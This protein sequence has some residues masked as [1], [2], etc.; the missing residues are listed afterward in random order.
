MTIWGK[1]LE[2][3][4]VTPT[5]PSRSRCAT[6]APAS[7]RK[8]RTSCSSC[9]SP[10]RRPAREPVLVSISS[11][12]VT[13]QQSGLPKI[14]LLFSVLLPEQR[15]RPEH[16]CVKVLRNVLWQGRF[17]R[18]FPVDQGPIRNPP[19][20]ETGFSF[21]KRV[22]SGFQRRL[23]WG[24]HIFVLRLVRRTKHHNPIN[25]VKLLRGMHQQI[26]EDMLQIVPT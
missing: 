22:I 10:A 16:V 19:F 13:Q 12:T 6:T 20:R 14:L 18:I 24:R 17:Q 15:L 5:G 21:R 1:T 8:S 2:V 23:I 25:A 4:T 7:R 11:D 26:I 9:S 3:T